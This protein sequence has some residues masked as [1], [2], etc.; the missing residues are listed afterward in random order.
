MERDVFG[1]V[2]RLAIFYDSFSLH[3]LVLSTLNDW[4]IVGLF[5][6]PAKSTQDRS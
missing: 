2:R 6:W 3:W 1:P 5:R 4:H